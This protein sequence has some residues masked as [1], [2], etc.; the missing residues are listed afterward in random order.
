MPRSYQSQASDDNDNASY[1]GEDS[2]PE[3][4]PSPHQQHERNPFG[5]SGIERNARPGLQFRS[6]SARTLDFGNLPSIPNET[7][8][9]LDHSDGAFG[10]SYRSLASST[11]ATPRPNQFRNNPS[12]G[13]YTRNHS[14]R[15]SFSQR[16]VTA[17]GAARSDT[18]LGMIARMQC[19]VALILC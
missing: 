11:P 5:I 12:S 10:R 4:A 15:G 8:S 6:R 19:L 18:P 2:L 7:S 1:E 9:L 13:R 3:I 17:L 16:L 14:R